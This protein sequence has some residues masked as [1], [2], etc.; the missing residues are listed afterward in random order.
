MAVAR[1]PPRSIQTALLVG[2]PVKNR[3]TSELKE[4]MALT[5]MMMITTPPTSSVRETILFIKV[6]YTLRRSIYRGCVT[7]L[8]P[9]HSSRSRAARNESDEDHD[10][11]NHQQDM[12]Q[13]AYRGARYQSQQ[14]Q[15][16][17]DYT[18]GP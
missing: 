11:G 10:D 14:P 9:H 17:Q 1:M 3:E 18:D 16:Y 7:S 15:N 6:V 13:T 12:N 4:F 8:I 5:P 2:E